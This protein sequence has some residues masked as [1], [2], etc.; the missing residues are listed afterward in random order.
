MPAA[1]V[2]QTIRVVVPATTANLGAGFDALALALD[3]ANVVEVELVAGRPGWVDLHVEGEGAGR[4]RPG[5]GNRFLSGLRTGLEAAGTD[6]N[7]WSYRITMHN[8]IPLSRGLG[9][10]AAAAV[11]GLMAARMLAGSAGAA[12]LPDARIL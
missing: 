7:R 9:S 8:E 2:G 10:S 6:F 12:A 1:S 5:R 11:G 4:L 3:M